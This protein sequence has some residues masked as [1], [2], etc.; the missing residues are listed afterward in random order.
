MNRDYAKGIWDNA[1]PAEFKIRTSEQ[2]QMTS[3]NSFTVTLER[4]IEVTAY[5]SEEDDSSKET[6]VTSAMETEESGRKGD[7]T[8]TGD[9]TVK[10]EE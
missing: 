5:T 3:G 6:D 10:P 1:D 9:G 2:L 8:D 4:D 7:T